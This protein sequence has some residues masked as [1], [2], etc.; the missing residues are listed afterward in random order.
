MLD[1]RKLT[2]LREVA[3]RGGITAAARALGLSPSAV[4]Q[5]ISRFEAEIGVALA[6]SHGRGISLT[7]AAHALVK[8]TETVIEVLETAEAE[9]AVMRT[10]VSGTVRIA[11]YPT[12]ALT[13]LGETVARLNETVPGVVVEFVQLDPAEAVTELSARRADVALIDEYPGHPVSAATG[14]TRTVVAREPVQAY[15]PRPG[16][17]PAEVSWAVEPRASD[18]FRWVQGICR[19]AGFDP[20]VRFESPDLHAHRRL[21]EQGIAAAFLPRSVARGLDPA[22]QVDVTGGSPHYRMLYT[23]TRRGSERSPAIAASIAAITATVRPIAQP[24]THTSPTE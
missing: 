20:L 6:E 12:F 5:Q 13:A 19:S 17:D 18:A 7:P 16:A 2:L 10:G 24:I 4:S 14:M 22:L 21:V 9:L 15:L 11:A 1:V 8:R 3:L 23:L